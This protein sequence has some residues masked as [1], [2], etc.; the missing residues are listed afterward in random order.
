[1]LTKGGILGFRI[2]GGLTSLVIGAVLLGIGYSETAL[3]V[4]LLALGGFV[5][6]HLVTE[7]WF[8][9][10]RE[11]KDYAPADDSGLREFAAAFVSTS[12]VILGL[13]AVFGDKPFSLTL[14]V[15][16]VALVTDILVGTVLVG[17]LL[18]GAASTDQKAWNLI[19]YV[20]NLAL[21]AL[22]LGLLCIALALVYR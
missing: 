16:I 2:V 12:G 15:G 14:K 7:A 10:V 11:N 20:F 19:R 4:A 22:S 9:S 8:L 1:V 18:A 17:L 13:L 6:F 3:S 21:W 5:L